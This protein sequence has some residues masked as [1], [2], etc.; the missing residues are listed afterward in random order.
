MRPTRP[1][2]PVK[3]PLDNTL[4]ANDIDFFLMGKAE[5]TPADARLAV[6]HQ[7]PFVGHILDLRKE[8]ANVVAVKN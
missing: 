3:T 2:D 4:P 6:G 5:I 8:G 7:R 1:G